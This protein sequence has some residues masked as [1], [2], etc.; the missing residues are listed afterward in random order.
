MC[1]IANHVALAVGISCTTWQATQ[2]LVAVVAVAVGVGVVADDVAHLTVVVFNTLRSHRRQWP[3]WPRRSWPGA[4]THRSLWFT[5]SL[6]LVPVTKNLVPCKTLP[7]DRC[8]VQCR[9]N[10]ERPEVEETSEV[11]GVQLPDKGSLEAVMICIPSLQ[12]CRVLVVVGDPVSVLVG[13]G[14]HVA[15]VLVPVVAVVDSPVFEARLQVRP[16][17]GK[18]GIRDSVIVEELENF[19]V[20][21]PT[22]LP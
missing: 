19:V 7:G 10:C 15:A 9:Q 5:S 21:H 1:A 20:E 12:I 2:S 18:L 11:V 13:E 17:S 6:V 16:M 4:I 14:C 3:G 8:V 22:L